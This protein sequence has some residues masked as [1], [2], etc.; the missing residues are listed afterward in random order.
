[1]QGTTYTSRRHRITN[2]VPDMVVRTFLSLSP[3][4]PRSLSRSFS[5]PQSLLWKDPIFC[6]RTR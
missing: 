1:M 3:L 4:S 5:L 2:S 6:A